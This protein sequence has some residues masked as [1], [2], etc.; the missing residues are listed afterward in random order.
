[1]AATCGA[2]GLECLEDKPSIK[3]SGGCGKIFHLKCTNSEEL[4]TRAGKK[5]WK[6]DEC[7]IKKD[8]SVTSVKSSASGTTALTKE[9]MFNLFE[10]FKQEISNQLK[11]YKTSVEFLSNRVDESNA[12][13]AKLRSEVGEIKKQNEKLLSENIKLTKEVEDLAVKVRELEQYSRKSNLEISGIPSTPN[14][15]TLTLL[16]DI[17]T[18]IGLE[19]L[20]TQVMA[21]HRVPSYNSQRTPSIVVQFENRLQRDNW[22]TNYKRKKT[23]MAKEVNPAFPENR[24]FINE[25]LS[26]ENKL[27]LRNL[28][29]KC[30]DLNIKYVWF[31]D[32]KFYVRKNDGER[33]HKITKLNDLSKV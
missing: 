14:E 16:K 33:C 11:D 10:A 9:F 31:R 7:S 19:L 32:G 13:I 2:C 8:S 22:I 25:H 20:E 5:D 27:F 12:L 17:G 6:C 15:N 30:K 18:A 26:P 1:M 29:L 21:A 23:L 24:V 28:K 3:C 4:K